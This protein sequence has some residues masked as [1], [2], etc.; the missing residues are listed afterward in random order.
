[1]QFGSIEIEEDLT[2]PAE[3]VAEVT[4]EEDVRQMPVGKLYLRATTA[5][6]PDTLPRTVERKPETSRT[7][8]NEDRSPGSKV[9]RM[10]RPEEN[11]M[12]VRPEAQMSIIPH[13]KSTLSHPYTLDS[14]I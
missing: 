14:T 10:D 2:P 12:A 13:L 6:S 11:R 7:V 9:Y 1:M 5:P 3:E 4:T 8:Q